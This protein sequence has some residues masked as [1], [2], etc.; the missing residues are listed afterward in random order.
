MKN[1]KKQLKKAFTLIELPAVS[2]T[3][4][5]ALTHRFS[6]SSMKRASTAFT[7][8][9]LICAMAILLMIGAVVGKIFAGSEI[10]WTR[11]TTRTDKNA[12]GRAALQMLS[13][14]LQYAV[15]YEDVDSAGRAVRVTFRMQEDRN[16]LTSY[17]FPNS[18][19]CFVSL[20]HD[21][22]DQ[23]RTAR[24]IH[25]YVKEIAGSPG[26]YE[27]RRHY[28]SKAISDTPLAHCYF[29]E[30]WYKTGGVSAQTGVPNPGRP[31]GGG[32][33]VGNIAG[34]SVTWPDPAAPNAEYDS[35]AHTNRV[36]EY[37]DIYLEVLSQRE[38]T[39][40]A[41]FPANSADQR[42][43]VERKARRF[44]SRVYFHNRHG[45]RRR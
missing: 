30:T 21:S 38:A 15:A 40:A 17:G 23:N 45:Y 14:D 29:N 32:V 20:Q 11:T 28:Y 13:H 7:L 9:E 18:E 10:I 44:T 1:P 6:R 34:F 36:P 22:A 43:Y 5:S 35:T 27:L 42:D 4:A 39:E 8:I 3:E 33:I 2:D 41:T 26:Q 37:V 25:Y 16:G 24:E 12:D 19:I 31:S